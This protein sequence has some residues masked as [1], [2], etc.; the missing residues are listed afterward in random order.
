MWGY[1]LLLAALAFVQEPGRIVGDTK[2]DLAVAPSSFLAR[3]WELWEPGSFMGHVQNQAYG[4]FWPMGPFFALGDILALPPWVTQRLWWTLLLCLAFFGVVQLARALGLG[5][6]RTQVLAGFAFALSAHMLTLVGPTSVEA[7]PSA[8]APWV[9]LPLV[10]ASTEGSVR[11]GAALSALVVAT[12]GGVNAVAVS[13]VLPLGLLW[14]LTRER[15]S[16]RT[17]L[18]GWW[19]LM[20]AL[21]TAW[22]VV[23]LLLLG[24]YSVPF[25]D[26]I[27]NAPITTLP[28]S[29][30]DVLAGTADWV[31]YV[32]PEDWYAG[33]LLAMTPVFL[34]NAVLVAAVGLAGIARRDNPHRAFLFLGLLAGAAL[35]SFG[36]T[37]AGDGWGSG[38]R[39]GLLDAELAPFRN[40]HKYDV[41]LKLPLVLGLA[42]LLARLSWRGEQSTVSIP[43]LVTTVVA[44]TAVAGVAA[45]AYTGV[46]APPRSFEQVPDY[47]HQATDYLERSQGD[48][49][50]LALPASRFGDFVWGSPHDDVLQPLMQRP[51]TLRSVLPLGQPGY[52]RV[53]DHLTE[54]VEDGRPS[55]ELAPFLAMHGVTRIV[56]RNDLDPFSSN[57]PDPVLLHQV[58][59][60]SPGLAK[61]A[62]FGPEV[63]GDAVARTD[64]DIRVLQ[65][66][67]WEDAYASVEV[68]SV[69][70]ARPRTTAWET[71][72]IPV[73]AGDPSVALQW[74]GV[75]TSAPAVLAG[76]VR[77][78]RFEGNYTVLT[79]GLKRR[80]TVFARVRNNVSA[81]LTEDEDWSLSSVV[82]NHRIYD[83]QADWETV[84]QWRG[85]ASV[86]ASSSQSQA[87]ALDLRRDRHPGAALDRVRRSAWASSARHG[88]VGQWWRVS[89]EHPRALRSVE[90]RLQRVRGPAVTRLLLATDAGTREVDAP[91]PG[92]RAV[93]TLPPG[94]TD[95]VEITATG[96]EGGGS[97]YQ[98]GIKEVRLDGVDAARVLA[99][100]DVLESSPDAVLLERADDTVTCIDLDDTVRCNDARLRTGED[101]HRLLRSLAFP[102]SRD[103]EVSLTAVPRRKPLVRALNE[104][105]PVRVRASSVLSRDVRASALAAVDQNPATAWVADADDPVPTLRLRW[106]RQVSLSDIRFEE[107]EEVAGANPRVVELVAGEETRRVRLRD[108]EASFAPLVTDSLVIRFSD[109]ERVF[110]FEGPDAVVLPVAVSEVTFPG[111]V[112]P[113]ISATMPLDLGCGSGP[114][115]RIGTRVAESRLRTT[116]AEVMTQPELTVEMCQDPEVEIP[117][118]TSDIR[119]TGS[120]FVRPQQLIL[121]DPDEELAP[122]E[123]EVEAVSWDDTHRVV[124]VARRDSPGLLVVNENFNRGW[125]ARLDGQQLPTQ[126]VDGWRQGFHLPPGGP[127]R[128]VLE[129][130]PNRTYQISLV[131][132]LLA[133]SA[134]ALLA[135]TTGRPTR[136]RGLG[137][138]PRAAG[139]SVA[140]TVLFGGFA[141]GWVGAAAA[142]VALLVVRGTGMARVA[143]PAAGGLLALAGVVHAWHREQGGELASLP[144]HL[145]AVV[146]V[147]LAGAGLV[148]KGPRFFRRRAGRSIT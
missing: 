66:R 8:L 137:T 67:G 12:A 33:H 144:A 109:V 96:V 26:Y 143:A 73:V 146:A 135:L 35:V 100:P 124:E 19:V 95:F 20:V 1:G 68:Y 101:G 52:V 5:N 88:A 97:G 76:D 114:R 126:R 34:I 127:Q 136:A 42:H 14:I 110:S 92:R 90:I 80:E 131:V 54:V 85:V 9:L 117:A 15:G 36:Y 48:G 106:D 7:W 27:E 94:V 61:V 115:V 32:S 147:V 130:E 89:L 116:L 77:D 40:V 145:L 72:S 70:S 133:L 112:V 65:N 2:F 87:D 69:A 57:R 134:V 93:F 37:G 21:A 10:R 39:Q 25:L 74:G 60:R 64:N 99:P 22:W 129:F 108:G 49:V 104:Q 86:S 103:Y 6:G 18:L 78:D 79:D 148:T 141:A 138:S 4:Y 82:P 119:V 132:G 31:A 47:W 139:A 102:T 43:R 56:V 122:E 128:V 59:D 142:L 53:L 75:I 111:A 28:T 13:A 17:A 58:L 105:L 62:E 91:E 50:T 81:T 125:V 107:R 83:D 3:A 11:R 140:A 44:V 41:V 123:V 16:R 113:G 120:P 23:P 29:M 84:A 46:L 45:P 98:F 63:G 38:L 51:W 71:D 121:T 118:G 55:E 24:A 30:P